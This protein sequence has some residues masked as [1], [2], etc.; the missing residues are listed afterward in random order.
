ME[1]SKVVLQDGERHIRVEAGIPVLLFIRRVP[2]E[3]RLS[4]KRF[5]ASHNNSSK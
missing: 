3:L 5:N 4:R 1:S 2:V